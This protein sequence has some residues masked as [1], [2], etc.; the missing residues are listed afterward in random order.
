MAT[1][2]EPVVAAHVPTIR[3]LVV[4]GQGVNV[5]FNQD[6]FDQF[7]VPRGTEVFFDQRTDTLHI[8]PETRPAAADPSRGTARTRSMNR[9]DRL[10]RYSPSNL[11][12]SMRGTPRCLR[13]ISLDRQ[14]SVEFTR[15]FDPSSERFWGPI[16]EDHPVTLNVSVAAK[17][18]FCGFVAPDWCRVHLSVRDDGSLVRGKPS[19]TF[20]RL[21]LETARGGKI[22]DFRAGEE[23]EF[24]DQDGNSFYQRISVVVGVEPVITYGDEAMHVRDLRPPY[25][26]ICTPDGTPVMVNDTEIHETIEINDEDEYQNRPLASR[27]SYGF[28]GSPPGARIQLDLS[29]NEDQPILTML[30]SAAMSG[31][32]IIEMGSI[33]GGGGGGENEFASGAFQSLQRALRDTQR[34]ASQLAARREA[35]LRERLAREA[36]NG[37]VVKRKEPTPAPAAPATDSEPSAKK[38]KNARECSICKE[39]FEK[40]SVFIPCGHMIGCDECMERSFIQNKKKCPICRETIERVLPT[41]DVTLPV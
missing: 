9:S 19:H 26:T 10:L 34:V 29:I 6:G 30:Q 7:Q 18:R 11:S 3:K 27:S 38:S 15:T 32:R 31:M 17:S 28:T 22:E 16:P 14:C 1:Q 5:I 4:S 2:A 35:E 12:S 37:A 20:P 41:Y 39:N 13:E 36:A 40:A 21:I 23:I 8:R 33:G 24:I 25:Y